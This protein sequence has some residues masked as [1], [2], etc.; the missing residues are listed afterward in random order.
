MLKRELEIARE[1]LNALYASGA[2]DKLLFSALEQ[3][4]RL[5]LAQATLD[6]GTED[7]IELQLPEGLREDGET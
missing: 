6:R 4:R 2:D 3:I 1:R 7:G 5:E